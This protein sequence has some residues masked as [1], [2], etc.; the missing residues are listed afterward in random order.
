MRDQAHQCDS[1]RMAT[2]TTA[3][4][5]HHDKPPFV[6]AVV[7]ERWKTWAPRQGPAQRKRHR[8]SQHDFIPLA[9]QG[10]TQPREHG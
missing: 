10:T 3:G 8:D 5:A 2:S 1:C 4:R 6:L 7:V 9:S